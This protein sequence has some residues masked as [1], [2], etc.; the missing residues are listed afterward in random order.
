VKEVRK[1]R[2]Q[3]LY[4]RYIKTFILHLQRTYKIQNIKIT[5]SCWERWFSKQYFFRTNTKLFK[6]K[7]H[8][9]QAF[10]MFTSD[11]CGHWWS[12]IFKD[13][14]QQNDNI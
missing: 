2:W 9:A 5:S 3:L 7:Y 1:Y 6:R 4:F 12:F 13:K 10:E 14:L 11:S 8:L